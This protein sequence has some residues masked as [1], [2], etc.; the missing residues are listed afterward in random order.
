[1]KNRYI[2]SILFSVI[3]IIIFLIL[4]GCGGGGESGGDSTTTTTPTPTT[5]PGS[6]GTIS[7]E[8]DS[9]T[10]TDLAGYKVY[11]G[12]ASG[13]YGTPKDAGMG[14][15]SGTKTTYDLTDPDLII[16]QTYFIAVT[17]YDT[18]NNESGY[19]NEVSGAAK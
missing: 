17:A 16:G 6:D 1:M 7:L 4:G 18:S 2:F 10:E 3:F 19:S 12:T 5:P 9:N 15:P 14:T 11:Y 8:W 13:V